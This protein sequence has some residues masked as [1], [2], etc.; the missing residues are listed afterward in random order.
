MGKYYIYIAIL[1]YYDI[2]KIYTKYKLNDSEIKINR[3]GIVTVSSPG[4]E[5][6]H[7]YGHWTNGFWMYTHNYTS[8]LTIIIM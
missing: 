8:C 4:D 6:T 7:F 5:D 3:N 2:L 1:I